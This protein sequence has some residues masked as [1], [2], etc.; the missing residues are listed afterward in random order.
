MI[1]VFLTGIK[2]MNVIMFFY[3]N[4]SGTYYKDSFDTSEKYIMSN[5]N[6][7]RKP[8]NAD[9]KLQAC[10]AKKVT[11]SGTHSCCV[12]MMPLCANNKIL[13]LTSIQF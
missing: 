6:C 2:K 5:E 13:R 11:V 1:E 8:L 9:L 10:R 7:Q 3:K 12:V 4:V